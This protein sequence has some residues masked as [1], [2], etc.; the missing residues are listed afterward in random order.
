MVI[1]R[2]TVKHLIV[3]NAPQVPPDKQDDTCLAMARQAREVLTQIP[4][5]TGVAFG[6]AVSERPAYR[7]LL[8]VEFAEEGVIA[9]YRDHPIHVRFANEVFRPLAVDRITTDYRMLL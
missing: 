3:F 4:G 8:I 6:V 7:Y 5:V 1:L 2:P 9:S